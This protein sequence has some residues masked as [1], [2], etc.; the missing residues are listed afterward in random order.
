MQLTPSEAELSERARQVVQCAY[1]PQS[2]LRVGAAVRDESDRIHVGCNVENDSYG[3]TLCAERAA[4]AAMVAAGGRRVMAIA[5]VCDGD[6]LPWPCG[7]CRQVLS[8]FAEDAPV[9]VERVTGDCGRATL[10]Q[11][12]PLAFRFRLGG[13]G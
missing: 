3:L 11:L 9:I 12:A 5:V 7:A 8:E 4:V 6:V 10:A 13:R 2:G 1:A